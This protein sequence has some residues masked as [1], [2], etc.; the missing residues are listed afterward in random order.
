MIQIRPGEYLPISRQIADSSD[1]TTYYVRSYIYKRKGSV[2]VLLDTIDLEDKGSQRFSYNYQ[3]PQDADDYYL[4]IITKVFT[5]SGYT[6]LSDMYGATEETHLVAERWGLQFGS[7]GGEAQI[8]YNKIKKIITEEIGKIEKP[9]EQ[10][11][12]DLSSLINRL[13]RIYKLVDV[14]VPKLETVNLAPVIRAIEDTKKDIQKDIQ[15]IEI[16]EQEKL[17]LIPVITK[18]EL[19]KGIISELI[20]KGIEKGDSR[21][22]E[23]KKVV[24]GISFPQSIPISMSFKKEEEEKQKPIRKRTFFS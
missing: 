21:V 7:G 9:Q 6:T 20:Q 14:E 16:P 23:I 22:E 13:E 24:K 11:E 18:I 15:K 1:S 3:V 10:K 19:L 17:D 5:D 8:N 12:I 2:E 4:S